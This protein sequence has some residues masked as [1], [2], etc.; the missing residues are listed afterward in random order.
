MLALISAIKRYVAT[1]MWAMG[2]INQ[3]VRWRQLQQNRSVQYPKTIPQHNAKAFTR[4]PCFSPNDLA[5]SAAVEAHLENRL[6]GWSF[7]WWSNARWLIVQLMG[8]W[9]FW[10]RVS[11]KGKLLKQNHRLSHFVFLFYISGIIRMRLFCACCQICKSLQLLYSRRIERLSLNAI[12]II[13]RSHTTINGNE[14]R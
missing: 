7:G 5:Q 10:G 12:D 14:R 9:I 11:P 1:A 8:D 2:T 13:E 6:A 4:T 3:S